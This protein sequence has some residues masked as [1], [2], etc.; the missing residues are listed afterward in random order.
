MRRYLGRNPVCTIRGARGRLRGDGGRSLPHRSMPHRRAGRLTCRALLLVLVG[1]G[2]AGPTRSVEG[3]DGPPPAPPPE[4]AILIARMVEAAGGAEAMAKIKNRLTEGHV[5][6]PSRGQRASTRS[7]LAGPRRYRDFIEIEQFG[8]LHFGIDGELVWGSDPVQGVRVL[9]GAERSMTLRMAELHFVL[10][11][12]QR[13]PTQRQLGEVQVNDRP[14]YKL[15]LTPQGTDEKP[16]FWFVD[17]ERSH[18]LRLELTVPDAKGVAHPA[19]VDFS[20]HRMVDG[21]LLAF[22]V[23]VTQG[24]MR[25]IHTLTRCEHN[26]ELPATVFVVPPEIEA[27]REGASKEET[28]G[29][30]TRGSGQPSESRP[31]VPGDGAGQR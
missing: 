19:A 22:Q 15:E 12:E 20:D 23:Q 26:V 31:R 21:V 3:Q 1:A 29:E 24:E 13:Y 11:I 25:I 16:E 10:G 18:L 30:P 6:I 28:K 8:T 2:L 14:C 4:P 27:L 17:R 5:V 7:Y 9:E